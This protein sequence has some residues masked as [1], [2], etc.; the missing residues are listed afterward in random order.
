MNR[1]RWPAFGLAGVV[2]AVA[3]FLLAGCGPQAQDTEDVQ[4]IED[5][6]EQ[7]YIFPDGTVVR[8]EAA[9][10]L[11]SLEFPEAFWDLR[12]ESQ[13]QD[14]D[15][16]VD[17]AGDIPWIPTKLSGE[18]HFLSIV[19]SGPNYGPHQRRIVFAAPE[20][21]ELFVADIAKVG[22]SGTKVIAS[23]HPVEYQCV[24]D[25]PP[26]DPGAAPLSTFNGLAHYCQA[27]WGLPGDVLLTWILI[28]TPKDEARNILFSQPTQW[29]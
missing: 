12:H 27:T 22:P 11:R 17:W 18:F 8:G 2:A 16:F 6:E 21:R 25:Y 19:A 29:Q 14:F 5:E 15:A 3:L 23:E 24:D 26:G 20:R 13:N 9:A 10:W 7:V 1:V 28:N 4:V